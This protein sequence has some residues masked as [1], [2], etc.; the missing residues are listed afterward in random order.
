MKQLDNSTL[1]ATL[2]VEYVA[3]SLLPELVDVLMGYLKGNA[4]K[5]VYHAFR[6][7]EWLYSYMAHLNDEHEVPYWY[8]DDTTS[9]MLTNGIGHLWQLRAF[10]KE[11]SA[12]TQEDEEEVCYGDDVLEWLTA[13]V[14]AS[15]VQDWPIY[16]LLAV[17]NAHND[18][19]H[20]LADED[21]AEYQ[22]MIGGQAQLLAKRL[23]SWAF[24]LAGPQEED[25]ALTFES[26][27]TP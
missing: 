12:E 7:M 14:P 20:T 16:N 18:N 13:G 23:E 11:S 3:Q 21:G 27:Y 24:E 26:E 9:Q 6:S 19:L 1:P 25:L 22:A 17:I 15:H 5:E 10:L 2:P 8:E 4:P